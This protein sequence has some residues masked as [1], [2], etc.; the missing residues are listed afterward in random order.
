MHRLMNGIDSEDET[1]PEQSGNTA[2]IPSEQVAHQVKQEHPM[3]FGSLA[4]TN[5]RLSKLL[6][7][8]MAILK[9]TSRRTLGKV[10]LYLVL[11]HC[12]S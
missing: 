11:R 4:V 2:G 10:R 1:R 8:T 7:P 12:T 6:E 3:A 5:L 9:L